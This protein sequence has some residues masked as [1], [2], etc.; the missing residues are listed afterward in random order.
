MSILIFMRKSHSK[1]HRSVSGSSRRRPLYRGASKRKY[2]D[3]ARGKE[4]DHHIQQDSSSGDLSSLYQFHCT[5]WIF[6]EMFQSRT[7]RLTEKF[8]YTVYIF[9]CHFGS[10]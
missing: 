3:G 5:D 6:D 2:D 9:F 4:E 8:K 10:F 7:K 1:L